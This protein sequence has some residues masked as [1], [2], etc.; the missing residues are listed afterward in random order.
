MKDYERVTPIV[1]LQ[2]QALNTSALDSQ[3]ALALGCHR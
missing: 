3:Q 1:C 2:G